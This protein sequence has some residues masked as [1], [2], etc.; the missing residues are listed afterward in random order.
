MTCKPFKP[1]DIAIFQNLPFPFSLANGQECEVLEALREH[2]IICMNGNEDVMPVYKVMFGTSIV[3][4]LPEQL[5][6]R[7]SPESEDSEHK[8]EPVSIWA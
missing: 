5:R 4:V 7:K 8:I 1:G 3:G 2:H 6:H